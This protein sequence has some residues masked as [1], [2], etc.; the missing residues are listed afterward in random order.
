MSRSLGFLYWFYFNIL[1]LNCFLPFIP[2][3]MVVYISLMDSFI[4]SLRTTN[5]FKKDCFEI[6]VLCSAVLVFSRPT[7]V[8]L[9]D[10]LVVF[11]LAPSQLGSGKLQF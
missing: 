9:L 8:R 10:V 6:L 4:L 2:L 11:K 5:M 7:V 1:V 3:F